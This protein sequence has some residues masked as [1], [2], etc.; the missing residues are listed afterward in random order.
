M[1]KAPSASTKQVKTPVHALPESGTWPKDY[2]CR[3]SRSKHEVTHILGVGH[4]QRTIR[5]EKAGQNTRSRTIWRQDT[6]KA[7][8][9]SSKQ[10]KTRG[11]AHPESG[12]R[13]K[14][15][16]RRASRSK[17]RITHNLRTGHSQS[18]I[19]IREVGQNTRS[20]TT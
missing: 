4:S 15:H 7:K 5:I 10:V 14:H 2:Q 1:A 18:T 3:A 17:H 12:T 20:R 11:H 8:S 13:P 16:Q 19:S 6:A 9:A